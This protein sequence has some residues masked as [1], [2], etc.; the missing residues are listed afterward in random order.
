MSR[1]EGT[2]SRK[3]K[4][5]LLLNRGL[6]GPLPADCSE[7]ALSPS[8]AGQRDKRAAPQGPGT[9]GVVSGGLQE[10]RGGGDTCRKSHGLWSLLQQSYR[11]CFFMPIS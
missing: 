3:Q 8:P 7:V 2:C 5:R 9:L 11:Q 10:R 1:S 6:P 4:K